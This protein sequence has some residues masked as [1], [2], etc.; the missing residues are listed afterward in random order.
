MIIHYLISC[1]LVC[2]LCSTTFALQKTSSSKQHAEVVE[3]YRVCQQFQR[4]LA[5][6][7]DFNAAF[8]ATFVTS[9]ARQR[10]IAI[11]DG[12]FGDV[13]FTGVDDSLIIDAYKSRMQIMYLM[14]PLASP[15]DEEQNLFFP[16]EIKQIFDRKSPH[17]S[18]EF[19][20][21]SAQLERDATTF[22]AH[23]ER[24]SAKYPSVVERVR[25]FKQGLV[26]GKFD[27]PQSE[28]KPL[29]YYGAAN[30]L[31]N[32]ES[33][34]QLEGYT[35]VRESGKMRIAGIRFITRLF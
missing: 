13:D 20:A 17:S 10:A 33:Y 6:H 4:I 34:Y 9:R 16:P 18:Q 26:S 30:V 14:F 8:E 27:P 25:N 15:S 29:Q 23:L 7:I 21:F 3:A 24:L 32:G 28:V 22:R 31:S 5:D 12:E 35:V 2:T 11:K 1:V 19:A